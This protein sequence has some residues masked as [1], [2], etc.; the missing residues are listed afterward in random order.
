MCTTSPVLERALKESKYGYLE[1][2]HG[3]LRTYD[4]FHAFRDA[5]KLYA[6]RGYISKHKLGFYAIPNNAKYDDQHKF[7]D[8]EMASEAVN[9]MQDA[10]DHITPEGWYFGTSMG[11][12]SCFG[13]WPIDDTGLDVISLEKKAEFESKK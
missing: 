7:W 8:T 3:T 1:V 2:S 12:G 10:L 4:L 9:D 6:P 13:W 11:D 5:L